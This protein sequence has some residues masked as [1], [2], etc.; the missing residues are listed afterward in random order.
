MVN[1]SDLTCPFEQPDFRFLCGIRCIKKV[2]IHTASILSI[3]AGE[4]WLG[5]GAAD[6]HR[7]QERLGGFSSAGSK[8]A[9]LQ[10]YRTPQKTAAMVRCVASDLERKRIY[11]GGRNGLLRLWD[12]T[13]DI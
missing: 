6:F 9:G 13:I 4:H 8:M 3:D 10:L 7:P 2:T 1:T 12:A 11:S 5:V